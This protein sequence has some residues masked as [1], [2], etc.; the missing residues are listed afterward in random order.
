MPLQRRIR[1]LDVRQRGQEEGH[2]CRLA[3]KLIT[4]KAR[5]IRKLKARQ[6]G[7]EEGHACRLA[8]KLITLEARMLILAA[9]LLKLEANSRNNSG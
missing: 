7:Q 6:Q 1:K 3:A 2:G 4:L 5:K 8:A 9:I